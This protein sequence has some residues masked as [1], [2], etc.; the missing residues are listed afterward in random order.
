[1]SFNPEPALASQGR[2]PPRDDH[3]RPVKQGSKMDEYF[4]VFS[5]NKHD[6]WVFW[7]DEEGEFQERTWF[8]RH[9]G[10]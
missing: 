5:L 6:F 3:W 7:N 4:G 9:E 10:C 1:V 2:D 8:Y